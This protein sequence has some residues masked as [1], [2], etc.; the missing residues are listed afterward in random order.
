M[1]IV[2]DTPAKR[3]EFE[4]EVVRT[5]YLSNADL[6]ETMDLLRMVLTVISLMEQELLD[7]EDMVQITLL[8]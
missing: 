2:P 5:F 7:S 6:K 1:L 8:I 4:D 3:R